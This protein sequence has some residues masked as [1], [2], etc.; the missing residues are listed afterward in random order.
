MFWCFS[1]RDGD[2]YSAFGMAAWCASNSIETIN[3]SCDSCEKIALF[4]FTF[5][6][7]LLKH[8]LTIFLGPFISL[9][10]PLYHFQVFFLRKEE[11]FCGIFYRFRCNA[12]E[13][14]TCFWFECITFESHFSQLFHL[15]ITWTNFETIHM[16]HRNWMKLPTNPPHWLDMQPNWAITWQPLM[17][18]R[19]WL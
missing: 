6:L 2:L 12:N 15:Q 17:T 16:D 1:E 10:N 9:S 18:N 4:R 19:C 3:I 8:Q 13:T 14:S 5:W 11:P 7:C